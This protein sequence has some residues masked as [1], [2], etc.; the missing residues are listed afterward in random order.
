[1]ILLVFLLNIIYCEYKGKIV[2]SDDGELTI[3]QLTDL[4]YGEGSKLDVL[5]TELTANLTKIT[6][7]DMVIITGDLVSGYMWNLINQTFFQD[8]WNMFT[9]AMTVPYAYVTGNH[10]AQANLDRDS[11]VKLDRKHDYSLMKGI[12]DGTTN[13]YIPVYDKNNKVALI[14]W[15]FDTN[16]EGCYDM[17]DSWG[18]FDD[19]EIKWYEEE[20][21]KLKEELGYMPNGLA[22]FHIPIPE[23]LSMHNW[24]RTY[25][26]RNENVSCPRKNS[27]LFRKILKMKN[28]KA[29]FCGHDHDNDEGGMFYGIEL[30]YGRKTG[31]GGY[32]PSFFK[33]GGRVIKIK[34]NEI[35]F[36]TNKIRKKRQRVEQNNK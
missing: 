28:I 30:V 13:Y 31:H 1:M 34:K 16:M 3:L 17:D 24:S 12:E 35:D 22:F 32:G 20:S 23:Y 36:R 29:T 2:L 6:N 15:M 7:P 8:C 14:L 5:S 21:N 11:I 25:G 26:S 27:Q 18:C 4:H 9:K 33:R 19:K 10:D